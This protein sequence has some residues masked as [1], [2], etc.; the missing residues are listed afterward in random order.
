MQIDLKT[1]IIPLASSLV[2]L[3][4]VLI[5]LTVNWLDKRS[6]TMRINT[7]LGQ[8]NNRVN[9]LTT[10]YNLQKEV[11]TPLQLPQ[12]KSTVFEELNDTFELFIDVVL[13]PD[14]ETKQRQEALVN[15]RKTNK[16][17]RAL[18]L[19][20]P[21]NLRGW[22]FHTGYYMCVL[23]LLAALGY[24]IFN[25]VQQR[26]A[27]TGIPDLNLLI[28]GLAAVLAIIFLIL[29][30]GAAKEIE[31][32]MMKLEKKTTPLRSRAVETANPS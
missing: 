4:P 19:Y 5:N 20:V 18:L 11:S 3:I 22:I 31:V 24:M 8:V 15:Y 10:W 6:Q 23:P 28:A 21:Y 9:F 1:L 16:F 12:I 27:L 29:G 13:D 25:L 26:S 17:R 30:R 2:G 14:K 7:I 32:R